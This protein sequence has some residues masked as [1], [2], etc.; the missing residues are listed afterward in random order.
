MTAKRTPSLMAA[1]AA[2]V[3]SRAARILD[4]PIEPE[5]SMTMTSTLPPPEA[6]LAPPA[7]PAPLLVPDAEIVTTALTSLAPSGRYSFWKHSRWKSAISLLLALVALTRTRALDP[8]GSLG[9]RFAH[10]FG[11]GRCRFNGR[12]RFSGRPG[13]GALDLPRNGLGSL[14]LR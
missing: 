7:N 12:C 4:P 8:R 2:A 13:L 3:A 6:A 11:S 9:R 10:G 14:R 1:T 5:V